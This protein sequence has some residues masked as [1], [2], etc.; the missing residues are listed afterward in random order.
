MRQSRASSTA[1]RSRLPRYCSS[2]DSNRENNAL[3]EARALRIP[4]IALIDT[5]GNFLYVNAG[6]PPPFHLAAS[7]EVTLLEEGGVVMGPLPDATYERGF[8]KLAPGDLLVL[9]TDG[10]T[11]AQ[12]EGSA[13]LDEYGRDRLIECV[14]ALRDSSAEDIVNGIFTDVEKFTVGSPASDDRTVC[15][16]KYPLDSPSPPAAPSAASDASR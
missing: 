12:P 6:H 5:D 4:T 15:V 7:G 14:K 3:R 11:E 9:Y 8:V 13:E 16:A 1:A 2:F 10:I